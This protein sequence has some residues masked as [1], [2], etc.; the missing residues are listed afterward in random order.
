MENSTKCMILSILCVPMV[1]ALDPP[2]SFMVLALQVVLLSFQF[3]FQRAEYKA[4]IAKL[5][6]TKLDLLD[7][8]RK[9]TSILEKN[10]YDK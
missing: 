8:L 3:C 5:E 10:F 6:K 9:R 4:L 2:Q 1:I 7:A